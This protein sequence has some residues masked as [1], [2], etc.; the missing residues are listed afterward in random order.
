MEVA[1]IIEL[2]WMTLQ[3]FRTLVPTLCINVFVHYSSALSSSFLLVSYCVVSCTVC[4]VI[5]MHLIIMQLILLYTFHAFMI[6]IHH[7]KTL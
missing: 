7:V 5:R 4:V 1:N 3:G 6:Y 2:Q